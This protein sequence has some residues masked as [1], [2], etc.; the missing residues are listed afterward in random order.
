MQQPP[1]VAAQTVTR[2]DWPKAVRDLAPWVEQAPPPGSPWQ[3]HPPA[4]FPPPGAVAYG[5]DVYGLWYDADLAGVLQRFRYI[6]PAPALSASTMAANADVPSGF[7][8]ADTACTQ[9]LW[10][11]VTGKLPSHF[12]GDDLPVEQVSWHEV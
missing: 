7:P 3:T 4:L 10:Q 11:A 2:S 9:A 5:R 1:P 6:P 8:L 12:K